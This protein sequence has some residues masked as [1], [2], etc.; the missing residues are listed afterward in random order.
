MSSFVLLSWDSVVAVRTG[1]WAERPKHRGL[2]LSRG[3]FLSI[4]MCL[5]WL[6]GQVQPPIQWVMGA[7]LM[8]VKWPGP[9]AEGL[10]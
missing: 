5:D 9:K 4:L 7:F 3:R 2:V 6:S 1:L 8:G 10:H